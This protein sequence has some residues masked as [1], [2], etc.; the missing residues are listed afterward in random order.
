MATPLQQA[1]G[2]VCNP[3]ARQGIKKMENDNQFLWGQFCRLG[4]MMGDGLHYE[5]DG[6][7]ISRE[8]KKLSLILIPELKEQYKA[9]R[10]KKNES[11]D[12]KMAAL[13]QNFICMCGNKCTQIRSG[14]L[15]V[16]CLQ[17]GRKYKA[18]AKAAPVQ[19]TTP[20]GRS[21]ETPPVP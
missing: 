7:W 5:S 11:R 17:C 20:A 4:E 8:Y 19:Q 2:V 10:I 13:L 18:K 14:S 9:Q 21:L 15:T 6:R 12:I 16:K 3:G 1:Q